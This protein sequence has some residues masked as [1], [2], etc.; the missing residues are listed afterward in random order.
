MSAAAPNGLL[1]TV[2]TKVNLPRARE[3]FQV[4]ATLAAA[5]FCGGPAFSVGW[6]RAD[7]SAFLDKLREVYRHFGDGSVHATMPLGAPAHVKDDGVDVIAW[8]HTSDTGPRLGYFLGQ[9]ASGDNWEKKSLKGHAETFHGTW[10]S[11]PP[12][13]PRVGTIMPFCLTSPSDLAA[14][15]DDQP[16]HEDQQSIATLRGRNRRYALAH[17]ELLYRHRVA[18]FVAHGMTLHAKGVGPIERVD[19]LPQVIAYV[20][21]FR[22]TLRHE[23]AV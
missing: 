19:D 1:S 2:E 17:G 12:P 18:L 3:L 23:C 6:P 11:S 16:N 22:E 8:Q 14:P 9:A 5:G 4:C 13:A 7:S 15:D 10:F 21:S 20:Q